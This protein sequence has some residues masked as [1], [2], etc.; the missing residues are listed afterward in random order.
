MVVEFVVDHV[1]STSCAWTTYLLRPL[2]LHFPL[3]LLPWFQTTT[4]HASSTDLHPPGSAH[5]R[6]T[7]QT[8]QHSMGPP[9]QDS[10]SVFVL[11]S[12][13]FIFTLPL[14]SMCEQVPFYNFSP[15]SS[16]SLGPQECG[17]PFPFK[18]PWPLSASRR[19]LA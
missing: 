19:R 1:L 5:R 15:V 11:G 14:L 7:I 6:L 17:T 8:P 10:S 4:L 16:Y 9:V 2:S 18:Y 12:P 13:T 3:F